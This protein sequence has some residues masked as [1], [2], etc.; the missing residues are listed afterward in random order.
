MRER[1]LF[2][3]AELMSSDELSSEPVELVVSEDHAGLRLDYFLAQQFPSYSRVHVRRIINAAGVKVDGKRA[4]AA[5]RLRAGERVSIILPEIR[6]GGS[7]P[8]DI[9]LD[10]LYEDADLAVINK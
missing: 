8:E 5:H 10:V 7:S 6:R 9:P 2:D 1:R 3:T 4:K